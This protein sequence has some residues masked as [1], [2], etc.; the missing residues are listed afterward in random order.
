[1]RHRHHLKDHLHVRFCERTLQNDAILDR[2]NLVQNVLVLF[3]YNKLFQNLLRFFQNRKIRF[4]T[5]NK[6]QFLQDYS[7]L[8]RIGPQ[9]W[10]MKS[11][12]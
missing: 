9:N 6:E 8:N 5:F 12:V 4:I 3:G 2:N 7:C 10:T 11:D 1:M